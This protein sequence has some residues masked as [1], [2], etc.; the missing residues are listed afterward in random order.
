MCQLCSYNIP[1]R[2]DAFTN[3]TTITGGDLTGSWITGGTSS[4]FPSSLLPF[5]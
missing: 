3:D 2:G 5:V 4:A 1:W